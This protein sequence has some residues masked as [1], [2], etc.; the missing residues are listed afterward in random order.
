MWYTAVENI[1]YLISLFSR[2]PQIIIKEVLVKDPN[3]FMPKDVEILKDHVKT[4][5]WRQGM[6][7]EQIAY[8]QGQVDLIRFIEEKLIKR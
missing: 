1:F 6:P 2:E 4:V 8:Q 5:H 3:G 7:I